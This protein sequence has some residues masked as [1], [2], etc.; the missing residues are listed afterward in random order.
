[1]D[2]GEAK[3]WTNVS[4]KRSILECMMAIQ[5]FPERTFKPGIYKWCQILFHSSIFTNSKEQTAHRRVAK[6]GHTSRILIRVPD[7][8]QYSSFPNNHILIF[9]HLWIRI[10][11]RQSHGWEKGK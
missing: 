4:T 11:F 9:C 1:M 10:L 5:S 7:S 8:A 6:N 3:Q 2:L